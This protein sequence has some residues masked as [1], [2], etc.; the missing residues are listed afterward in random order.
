MLKSQRSWLL[1]QSRSCGVRAWETND[2]D[3]I[4][5]QTLEC[6]PESCW[7]ESTGK[8]GR[9]WLASTDN[10]S[11]RKMQL[12]K[13]QT[14]APPAWRLYLFVIY[15]WDRERKDAGTHMPRLMEVKR[16]LARVGPRVFQRGPRDQILG[17]TASIFTKHPEILPPLSLLVHSIPTPSCPTNNTPWLGLPKSVPTHIPIFSGNTSCQ[18]TPRPLPCA[19][20][21]IPQVN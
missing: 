16:Q 10:T 19:L 18:G 3:S 12:M 4:R 13:E 15:V 1:L 21:W 17:C 20:L 2:R 11:S 9:S 7:F 8:H 6:L 5:G 14:P